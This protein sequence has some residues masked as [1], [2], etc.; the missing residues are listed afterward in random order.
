MRNPNC[1]GDCRFKLPYFALQLNHLDEKLA[2]KLPPTDVRFRPD[3]RLFEEGYCA[4]VSCPAK[5]CLATTETTWAC[6]Y[7]TNHMVC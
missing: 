6:S 4:A 5:A 7:G 1:V 3:Q 2:E